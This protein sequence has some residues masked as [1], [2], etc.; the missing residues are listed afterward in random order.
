M[1]NAV[2]SV[3]IA[4]AVIAA[5]ALLGNSYTYKFR[6]NQTL[7]VTG[8]AFHDFTSD[9][10]VWRGSFSRKSIEIKDAYAALKEDESAIRAYLKGKGIKEDELI[11][12]S[13]STQKDM[14]YT[15]DGH[16]GS[17]SIFTGYTLTQTLKVESREMEKVEKTSREITELLDRGIVLASEEPQY[18]YTKLDE[19]KID[20]LAGASK[21]GETRARTIAENAGSKLGRLQKA[22]MGIFQIT[23]QNSDED[24]SWGG[25]FNTS[26]KKKT[27]SVT[28]K[29]DF[30]IR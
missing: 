14:E 18:Y 7:T 24:Y 9:L 15:G 30:G 10:I 29:M 22:S 4:V 17:R 1:K 11:F 5:A 12:S 19:L 25:A 2:P 23:G 20:L 16:G 21:D 26:S 13:V 27:A 8:S 6:K 3:I 28:I